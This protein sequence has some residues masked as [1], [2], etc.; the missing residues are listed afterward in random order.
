MI[1]AIINAGLRNNVYK[2]IVGDKIAHQISTIILIII[3][4]VM[5]YIIFR[6]S[7]LELADNEALL[8]GFL[9]FIFTMVFEFLAGHYIFGSSWDKIFADY[10]LLKGRI[11]SLVLIIILISPYVSNKFLQIR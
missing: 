6:L 10:N 11:W 5:T 3:I 4:L 1:L 9:W 7:S 2:P 8:M